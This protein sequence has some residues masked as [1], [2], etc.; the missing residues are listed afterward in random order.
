[1]TRTIA[2]TNSEQKDSENFSCPANIR[3]DVR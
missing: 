1:M 2:P 3:P